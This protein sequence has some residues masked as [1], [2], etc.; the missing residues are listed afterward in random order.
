MGADQRRLKVLRDPVHNLVTLDGE[1]GKLVLALIDRPEFQRLRRVRQLGLACLTYP[2]AEHTRWSHS[3]GVCY[4]AR[5]MV[6]AL[7]KLYGEKSVEGRELAGVRREIISAALLHDVG[8]GPFSHVF[9]RAIHAPKN[10][11][12]GYPADHEGWSRRVITERFGAVLEKHGVKTDVVANLIDKKNRGNPLA[13]DIISS[14]LDADRMDYLLRDSRATGAR[15]GEFDLEWLLHCVRIG[16]VAV[17]GRS[18]S[19]HRLCFDAEKAIHVVEEYIQAREF[20]YVQVYLHKTTRAFEAM[21]KSVLGL[22]SAIADGEEHF[23]PQPCPP[24]LAKMLARKEVSTDEYLS[25]DDFRL[26]CTLIDWSGIEAKGDKR[27]ERLSARCRRLVNRERPFRTIRLETDEECEKWITFVTRLEGSD[28]AQSIFRDAFTDL[29]YRSVFYRNSSQSKAESG[30]DE[31]DRAI[32]FIDANG[33]AQPAEAFS[34][35]IQAISNIK[36]SIHRLYY[37]E[38]DEQAVL[39]LEKEGFFK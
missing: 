25:L 15:Y 12:D 39:G 27:R 18:D 24:A 2:G 37:D 3:F 21:L 16:E 1:D 13:K 19:L 38:T 32:Y 28:V 7:A 10:P 4:V 22:A 36:T 30:E 11:A 8:H 33:R 35:V 14:Q 23:A 34:S 6:D 17:K 20:M 5:R 29:A 26:W 31:S 9:E